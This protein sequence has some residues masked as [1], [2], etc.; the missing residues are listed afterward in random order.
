MVSF[1]D[2]YD[3][4]ATRLDDSLHVLNGD[5]S[6]LQQQVDAVRRNMHEM[7]V[8]QTK[9]ARLVLGWMGMGMLE[10]SRSGESWDGVP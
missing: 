3:K 5:I 8:K 1:F 10:A 7:N 4:Q 6:R 2:M 9:E